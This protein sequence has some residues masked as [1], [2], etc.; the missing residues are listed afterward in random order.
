MTRKVQRRVGSTCLNSR[1]PFM[2]SGKQP[3]K[4]RFV[5]QSLKCD[6]IVDSVCRSKESNTIIIVD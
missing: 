6:S 5:V 1:P 3:K 4:K 2:F